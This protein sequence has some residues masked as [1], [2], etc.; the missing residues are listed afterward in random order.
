MFSSSNSQFRECGNPGSFNM[1]PVIDIVF[2]LIV[3]FMVVCRFIEAEN[4]PVQVPDGCEYARKDAEQKPRVTTVTVLKNSERQCRFV[5]GAEE[6]S[7]LGYDDIVGKIANLLDK[8]LK[9]LPDNERVVTLRIDRQVCFADAQYAL[10]G[11]AESI[12]T[13]IKLATLKEH[14]VNLE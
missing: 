13:N 7:S 8:R 9:D 10:A 1:T 5:V 6:I 2:L 3:F 12:A 14:R 4:F 11:I